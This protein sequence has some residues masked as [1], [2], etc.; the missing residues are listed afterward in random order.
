MYMYFY[1]IEKE[2]YALINFFKIIFLGSFTIEDSIELVIK[3]KQI[4]SLTAQFLL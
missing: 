3:T 4:I 2:I 1:D